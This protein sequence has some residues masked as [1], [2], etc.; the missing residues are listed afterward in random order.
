ME[1]GKKFEKA[2]MK[3]NEWCPNVPSNEKEFVVGFSLGNWNLNCLTDKTIM[4]FSGINTAVYL[5]INYS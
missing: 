5:Q 3:C 2:M 1:S 4:D